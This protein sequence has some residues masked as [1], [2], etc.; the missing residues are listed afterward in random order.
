M[1]F[2]QSLLNN[3]PVGRT[4]HDQQIVFDGVHL[5]TTVHQLKH[6]ELL[7]ALNIDAVLAIL[8]T[9]GPVRI[10]LL[11]QLYHVGTL[12]DTHGQVHVSAPPPGAIEPF[13]SA[14]KIQDTTAG[15]VGHKFNDIPKVPV[16]VVASIS[17]Y[18]SIVHV[19]KG[20]P[21]QSLVG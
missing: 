20:L 5:G 6:C 7:V 10:D 13:E 2:D 21:K 9:V 16:P 14:I 12:L 18:H 8:T 19:K 3:H 1:F 4:M 15:I 11:A 17:V